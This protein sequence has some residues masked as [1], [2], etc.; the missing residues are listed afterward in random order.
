MSTVVD[1]S[2][3]RV[4]GSYLP[5][6]EAGDTNETL[7]PRSGAKIQEFT[8]DVETGCR[9]TEW[10]NYTVIAAAMSLN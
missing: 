8:C 5:L 6:C 1:I 3:L 7:I 2:A 9:C 4:K 10:I